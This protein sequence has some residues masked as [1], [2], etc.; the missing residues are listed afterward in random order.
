M[1]NSE[2][3]GD[4]EIEKHKLYSIIPNHGDLENT[5]HANKKRVLQLKA[6]RNSLWET[7]LIR[8]VTRL[9]CCNKKRRHLKRLLVT[10]TN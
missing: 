4:T 1:M 8:S 9:S 6:D 10:A 3:T 5:G 2:M 7:N